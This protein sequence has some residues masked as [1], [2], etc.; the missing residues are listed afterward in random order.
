MNRNRNISI[1]KQLHKIFPLSDIFF[2]CRVPIDHI[3]IKSYALFK[4][5][6]I[7]GRIYKP[8]TTIT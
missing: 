8:L 5:R 1:A 7:L 6:A 4:A 3:P 2:S